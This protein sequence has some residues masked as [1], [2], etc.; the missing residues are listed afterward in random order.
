[1]IKITDSWIFS[2]PVTPRASSKSLSLDTRLNSPAESP[3]PSP[4]TKAPTIKDLNQLNR[5]LIEIQLSS[6]DESKDDNPVEE[7]VFRSL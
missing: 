7:Y 4:A 3:L 6:E 5:K 2:L 1:M